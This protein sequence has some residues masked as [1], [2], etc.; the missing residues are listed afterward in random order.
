MLTAAA[1]LA[2]L[3]SAS[4]A[5]SATEADGTRRIIGFVDME[6]RPAADPG[7]VAGQVVDIRAFGVSIID[8]PDG[9][10]A[11]LGWQR[12][13]AAS[14]RNDVLVAGNPLAALEKRPDQNEDGGQIHGTQGQ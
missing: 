2:T 11:A 10:S 5:W 4:C 8:T 9:S 1:L 14:L 12:H 3:A 7:V 6:V 13:V